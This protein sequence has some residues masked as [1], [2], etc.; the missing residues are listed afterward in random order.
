MRDIA[1]VEPQKFAELLKDYNITYITGV[2]DSTLKAWVNFLNNSNDNFNFTHIKAVNECEAI[3]LAA[4]YNI[5]SKQIAMVYFQ[6]SGLGKAVNP[7]TSLTD[8]MV[9]SLPILLLI[10]WRGE[11]GKLDD[12]QHMKIGRIMLDILDDLEIPYHILEDDEENLIKALDAAKSYM[13]QTS[14]PYALIC[15]KNFFTDFPPILSNHYNNDFTTED[16]INRILKNTGSQDL[17]LANT[18]QISR[19]LSHLRSKRNEN[20]RDFYTLGSMGCVSAIGLGI[21]NQTHKKIIVIDGD[22]SVLMQLGTI[23]QIGNQQPQNLYHIIIDNNGY[24]STGCQ[25]SISHT[26]NFKDIAK[27]CSYKFF[28]STDNLD[29]FENFYKEMINAEGPALLEVKVQL[30]NR[31]YLN[32]LQDPLKYKKQFQEAIQKE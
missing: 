16:V 18:G 13:K 29:E 22:G 24:C 30:N 28:K 1:T 4:G 14:A 32:R 8:P 19:S 26:V 6:N 7:L 5:A 31:K 27:A 9:F 2:P 20:H 15:K 3:A 21:S 25:P 23:A 17:I 11:P 12:P 10:G